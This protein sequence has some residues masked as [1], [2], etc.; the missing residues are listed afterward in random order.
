MSWLVSVASSVRFVPCVDVASSVMLVE[1]LS[2]VGL[3]GFLL[4]VV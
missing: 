1:L 4:Q 2:V 3:V